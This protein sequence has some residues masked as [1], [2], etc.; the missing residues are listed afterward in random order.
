MNIRSLT[1]VGAA[2]LSAAASLTSARAAERPNILWLDAEDAN[3]RWFGCYGNEEART[4]NIDR[5][6]AEGF[7]YLH[8]FANAPVSAP[9]RST[10]I[11]G[12]LAVSMGTYPMRSRYPI[13]HDMIRYYPDYLREAGYFCTQ[14]GK[15]DYNIAGRPDQDAWEDAA[16]WSGRADGQPFFHVAHFGESHENRA[17]GDVTQS[18][19]DPARQRLRA[20][21]PDI[22]LIR[23]NYAHYADAVEE[24]DHQIGRWLDRLS[25]EGLAD[26]T[27]VIFTTDHGGVM[28]RSK[29][30]LYDTG[31]RSPF[32]IRIPEKFSHLWPAERPGMTVDRLVSFVDMPKTWLSMAG[33]NIPAHFHGRVI[34]GPD[35][36]PPR[37]TH[38]AFRGRMGEVIDEGRAVHDTRYL[39][40]RNFLPRM[41][42]GQHHTYQWRMQASRAWEAHH[43]AGL[44]DEVTGRFFRPREGAEELYDTWNDPDQVHNL[45]DDPD[46]QE[47]LGKMRI[48][49]REWQLEVFDAGLL[50]ETER[51]RRAEAH[52]TTIFEMVR[53]PFLYDLPAYL[54]AA[55]LALAGDPAHTEELLALLDQDDLALRYWG[56]I[57]LLAMD[58]PAQRALDALDTL[59]MDESHE[60]RV[61][62][63]WTLL[64][65]GRTDPARAVL[66]DL[67][68]T[69]SYATL[70][71]L[72]VLDRN[73]DDLSFYKEA[74]KSLPDERLT[75]QIRDHLIR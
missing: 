2:A 21:H 64:R 48:T 12:M 6:A 71:A 65:A 4:P 75:N 53:D 30:F 3:I 15:T 35:Q 26:N 1:T 28:P 66:L 74:I 46:H 72:N 44:T 22:P 58:A 49:L 57:G 31:L 45:V 25:E 39:Y 68:R 18:R 27:I 43:R 19:H 9:S 62:A 70:S 36:E 61:I 29:R 14:P 63:A 23:M 37:P 16:D 69:R 17:F 40:I 52:D 67:L 59:L 11:T 24:L 32:I 8:A 13:P 73:V 41:T 10:W 51:L 60:V 5:L 50:P 34:L 20:Y 42:L 56:A 33:A 54:D 55:D 47:I 38:F 7:Q